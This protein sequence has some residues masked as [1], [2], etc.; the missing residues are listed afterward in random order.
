YRPG[1]DDFNRPLIF[2]LI[3]FYHE[4]DSWLFG[5]VYH[6]LDRHPDRYEVELTVTA[7]LRPQ[8]TSEA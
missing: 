8:V 5:G 7:R 4:Q 3:Q 2:S 6:V 1:R